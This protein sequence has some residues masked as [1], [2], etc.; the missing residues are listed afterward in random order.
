[1]LALSSE[2]ILSFKEISANQNFIP[3]SPGETRKICKY[4]MWGLRAMF[5]NDRLCDLTGID[6]AVQCHICFLCR[7]LKC[8]NLN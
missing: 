6:L 5:I 2:K 8:R 4:S 1:M 3:S 7:S